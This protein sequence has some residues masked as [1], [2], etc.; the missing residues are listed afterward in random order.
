MEMYILV[1]VF[2]FVDLNLNIE[3]DVYLK[4]GI[5]YSIFFNYKD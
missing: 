1:F 4:K 2:C 3:N 5:Y